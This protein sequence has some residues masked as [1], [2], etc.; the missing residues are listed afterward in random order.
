MTRIPLRW[1]AACYALVGAGLAIVFAGLAAQL[2]L[3]IV[4]QC[5]AAA[6][7]VAGL[8]PLALVGTWGLNGWLVEINT[9]IA[10]SRAERPGAMIVEAEAP[11][12]AAELQS[13]AD[14]TAYYAA[15]KL[16]LE[17]LDA[18]VNQAGAESIQIPRWTYLETWSARQWSYATSCLEEAGVIE[19]DDDGTWVKAGRLNELRD[20]VRR[21]QIALPALRIGDN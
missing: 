18:A 3:T 14:R 12:R 17:L 21:D 2:P 1:I 5:V 10:L 9:R 4:G 13:L 11:P 7:I 20:R 6:A 8:V 19:I 15:K 16:V